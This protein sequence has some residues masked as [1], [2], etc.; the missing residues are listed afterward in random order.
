MWLDHPLLLRG[1]RKQGKDDHNV[2]GCEALKRMKLR[3]VK[4]KLKVW[5]TEIFG[6]FTEV[7]NQMVK[8]IDKADRLEALGELD[9]G[10]QKGKVEVEN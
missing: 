10:A 6:N 2:Y 4:E 1:F 7:K 5:N 3:M 8:K 9:E